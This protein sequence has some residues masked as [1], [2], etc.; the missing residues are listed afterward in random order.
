MTLMSLFRPLTPRELLQWTF[1]IY[2]SDFTRW[3]LLALLAVVPLVIV[4]YAVAAVLPQPSFDPELL[5]QFLAPLES[6][7]MLS[8]PALQQEL[9][10]DMLQNSLLMLQ[11]LAI[12]LLAQIIILGTIAGGAGAVMASAAYQG[13]PVDLG[14]GLHA[15]GQRIGALLS[16]HA[17]AGGILLALLVVSILGTAV[18]IGVLGMGLTIFV[19]LALIPL[20]APALALEEG[21]AS[22]LLRRAWNFGKRQVWVIFGITVAL[23]ALR[24]LLAFPLEIIQGLVAPESLLVTQ[25]ITILVEVLVL[26]VGVIFFT[27][28]YEDSRGRQEAAEMEA[29]DLAEEGEQRPARRQPLLTTADLPHLVGISMISLGLLFGFYIV[30]M[31]RALMLGI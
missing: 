7:E 8:N 29:P 17:I 25:A 6:G 30:I 5:D 28:L 21:N 27:L 9:M 20:A 15:L 26:P 22:R 16:G 14:A 10:D 18:C 13:E 3:L 23:Y 11:L 31:L 2:A 24:L 12:Q 1:R 19:Y 4:N